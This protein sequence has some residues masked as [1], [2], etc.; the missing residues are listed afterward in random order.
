[1]ENV[2]P[3]R[4]NIGPSH[5]ATHHLMRVEADIVGETIEYCECEIGYVHRC[6]EK[7]AEQMGWNQVITL[8]D[9]LNYCSAPLNNIG[10]CLAVEK[11][12]GLEVPP[13]AV[14]L[15]TLF[16]ELARIFDHLLCVGASLV[17]LGALTNFWYTFREREQIYDLFEEVCGSRLTTTLTRVGG[18]FRDVKPGYEKRV[19]EKTKRLAEAVD[20]VDNL[21]TK[22]RIAIDRMRGVGPIS[23][24]DAKSYGFTGPCLR[25]AGVP[26]DVRKAA[27]YLLYGQLDF[28]V[29]LG[30]HG[31]CFDRYLVRMEE[32]RQSIHIV[33]QLLEG[34]PPGPV[35]VDNRYLTL[36]LKSEVHGNIE[37][38]MNHFKL[39][40]EGVRVPV[41]EVYGYTEA[42]NGELGFY[43]VSDGG[44]QPYRIKVRPPCFAV[45]QAFPQMVKGHMIADVVAIMAGMNIIAGELDR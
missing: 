12:I 1:M 20:D 6:F 10:Y 19:R 44:K 32:I 33:E 42:G 27:P 25:A 36:P 41:G 11:L 28:K 15:R 9:R 34:I 37:A 24:D 31:D 40:M 45:W 38:L 26:Y 5:N 14:Y 7:M 13:R 30:K 21:I 4:I 39:V 29:P 23:A 2:K 17:D 43:L 3:Y 35:N 22:N 18:L 8:T 16:S